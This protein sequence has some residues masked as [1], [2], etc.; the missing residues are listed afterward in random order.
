MF[1]PSPPYA[2]GEVG[3]LY[4]WFAILLGLRTLFVRWGWGEASSLYAPLLRR[5]GASK[6]RFG[7]LGV[8]I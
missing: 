8:W 5:T 3:I 4:F 1:V 2:G 7:V 6:S